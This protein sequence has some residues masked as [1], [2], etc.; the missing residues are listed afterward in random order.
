MSLAG[1][2][3]H[4]RLPLPTSCQYWMLGCVLSQSGCIASNRQCHLHP[5]YVGCMR[6]LMHSLEVNSRRGEHPRALL[7]SPTIK[8]SR[9]FLGQPGYDTGVGE[10]VQAPSHPLFDHRT[11]HK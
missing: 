9:A 5:G 6:W 8:T 10:G 4:S 11:L 2:D 3:D 1:G 7:G